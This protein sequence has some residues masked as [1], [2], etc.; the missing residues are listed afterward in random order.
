MGTKPIRIL[1]VL[2][3]LNRGGAETMVMN[4]Y[5]K[6][7]RSR[8]QFDFIIHTEEECD[9]TREILS[10][11]GRIYSVPRY[12]GKNHFKY[13][14]VWKEFLKKHPDY[15]V[16]HG[17]VR[18]TA[19]IYL[20]LAKR[21]GLITIAHSHNT[22]SG[23]GFSSMV[24]NILQYP[25]RHIA[26][27]LFACSKSAGNWLFG[28]KACKKGNF[29]VINNAIE[30]K[31]F[32]FNNELRQKKRSEL[33]ID[34]K[35]VIG[36]VG[37]FHTQKNHEFLIDIFK[38]VHLQN[39]KS[40]LLLVGEGAQKQNIE[41]KVKE[42]GLINNVI[43]TGVRP[44]IP[45]L[46]QS[47][48]IFLFPSLFEGLPVTLVEAQASGIPCVV[49]K[50]ITDEIG[51]TSLLE[52]IAL[53]KGAEYWAK[54]VLKYERFYER[55]NTYNDIVNSHY[56]ISFVANWYQDFMLNQKEV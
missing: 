24:K 56:D 15:K 41:H 4:L 19:S 22:S 34:D 36:H 27:Y 17:H 51:V 55:K 7:D 28:K 37:R 43:F 46:L 45:D 10:L 49:S 39:E 38:E 44:D 14:K 33:R 42:L 53:S 13:V 40:V 35:F 11:G 6:I 8:L 26:D 32:I 30:A 54:V 9:Y 25:I 21:F 2:G 52:S 1:H 18:S 50:N 23:T 31:K 5:R 16:I 3:K 47:M 29:F 48:D 20:G 12:T